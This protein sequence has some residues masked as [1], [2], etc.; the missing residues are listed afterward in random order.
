[1]KVGQTV[2]H[3][4][5]LE[6]LG[7][8]GMGEVYLCE[9]LTLG[10]RVALKFLAG[11]DPS[12]RQSIERFFR[13]ARTASAL[14]HPNICTIHEIGDHDGH[15]FLVLEL[16]DGR[17]LKA[18]IDERP[19]PVDRVIALAI[20]IADA[21]DAAHSI[22]IVH[23]D[24]KPTNIIVNKRG[25]AKVLDF[26]LAK[27]QTSRRGQSGESAATALI[28]E[29]VTTLGT[30]LGTVAYM[31]PEQAR[32][33][34]VDARSD[35]FSFGIVLYQMATGRP[36]FGG[37]T[38]AV[39]FDE[40]LNRVPPPAVRLN[41][42]LPQEL[43]R[44]ISKALEKDKDLRYSSA[45]E[46]R[47]DLKRLKRETESGRTAAAPRTSAVPAP[48]REAAAARSAGRPILWIAAALVCVLAAAAGAYFYLGGRGEQIDS[49]AVL[50]FVNSSGNPDTEYLTDGITETLINNLS[51]LPGVRV[52]ARSLAFR[53]KGQDVDPLKA[54]QEL[55]VRAVIT[56]RIT[57]RGNM[58]IIQSDLVDVNNGSQLW[59]GQYNRPLADILAV[60]D[61]ISGEIFEKLRLRLTGEEKK[62]ATKRYTENAEA[63]QLYLRGRYYW[64]QGTVAGFKKA[65][66]YFQDASTQD[67][68]YALAHAGLA[69]SYLF[70]G[71]YFV[72]AIPEAKAAALK[73]LELDRTLAEAHVSMGHI[74]LWLDWDWPAAELE[75]KQGIALNPSS[76][77]AHNQ[78]GMYLA[79][80]GRLDDAI[81]EVKLAQELDPLSPIVNTDLGWYLLYAGRG[82]DAVQQFRKTLELD[83]NYLAARWGLGA[84]YTQQQLYAQAIEELKKA[85]T[86]SE[87]S[88]VPMGHLG[89]V[90]GLNKA[91]AEARQTLADLSTLATRQYVPSSTF[92]L[93][94]AGL[95]DKV[96]ALDQLEQAYQEHDFSMVFLDVAPWFNSLRGEPRF[97]Q[98]IR[99]MQLPV[100]SATGR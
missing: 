12:D 28:D 48:V 19:L 45:A 74:K 90:Y 73:A 3:Y 42:A 70:L 83:A 89:F 34:E 20:Q 86:L 63:Y 26:G 96:R 98:L 84:A 53:Y 23:R 91:A 97:E 13:E 99:R 5:V 18:E 52:S 36:P 69:D 35:L 15:P 100:R 54:G 77:L 30:T 85:V 57:T 76:A 4:R 59:G 65:I 62:R 6:K 71:S 8:G 11:A 38:T 27:L 72:E 21:L 64:N 16:L 22:G 79:A 1:V 47:A 66:E 95:G 14:N 92:A 68:K 31:S 39:I 32:G 33:E 17:T 2:S 40:I 78:Y 88:P 43:D 24:I 87:G 37:Q 41:A 44:I 93:V 25:E 49:M 51:Q 60:Q 58:L 94:H 55:N 46:I 7:S 56:G 80:M 82:S 81:A 9:D 67:P 75:F 10:R 29:S 50:P 61:E